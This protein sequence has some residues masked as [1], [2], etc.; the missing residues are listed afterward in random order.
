MKKFD[1]DYHAFFK[2]WL[3]EQLRCR[4]QLLRFATNQ[5]A[6]RP[7]QR[8]ETDLGGEM[9]H[10]AISTSN[11]QSSGFRHRPLHVQSMRNVD[12]DRT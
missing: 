6:V 5:P 11:S 3:E 12:P 2:I 10:V 8:H 7:L 9:R 4:R 1:G